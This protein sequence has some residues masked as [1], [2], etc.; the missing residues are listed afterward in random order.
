MTNENPLTMREPTIEF[1]VIII[2]HSVNSKTN[3]SRYNRCNYFLILNKHC[4]EDDHV[5][6]LPIFS[7]K[8]RKSSAKLLK[9]F[10]KISYMYTVG[11]R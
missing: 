4:E 8:F 5:S 11:W 3:P 2:I 9:I 1:L 10:S 7:F 6:A